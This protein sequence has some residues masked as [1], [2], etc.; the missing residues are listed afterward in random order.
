M[1]VLRRRLSKGSHRLCVSFFKRIQRVE[2]RVIVVKG[3][4]I[5][6]V[7]TEIIAMIGMTVATP[8]IALSWHRRSSAR[9]ITL[10]TVWLLLGLGEL[11]G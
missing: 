2:Q 11:G 1:H 5:T 8:M 10:S 3:V 6:I 9:S 7:S 4:V